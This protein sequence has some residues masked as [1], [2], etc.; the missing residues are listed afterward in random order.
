MDEQLKFLFCKEICGISLYYIASVWSN[1]VSE[2]GGIMKYEE[3]ASNIPQVFTHF[4][5][6]PVWLFQVALNYECGLGFLSEAMLHNLFCKSCSQ[7]VKFS[8][9]FLSEKQGWLQLVAK[10]AKCDRSAVDRSACLR[11][12]DGELGGEVGRIVSVVGKNLVSK[13][14]WGKQ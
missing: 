3:H 13:V 4:P 2:P 1:E 10:S 9:S 7:W 11:G 12:A 5:S 8:C 6:K 14:L